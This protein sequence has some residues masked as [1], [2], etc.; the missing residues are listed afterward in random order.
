MATQWREHRDVLRCPT[1]LGSLRDGADSLECEACATTYPAEDGQV[2]LRIREPVTKE[3][4]F[5]FDGDYPDVEEFDPGLDERPSPAVDW[6]DQPLPGNLDE[7]LLS[8]F[9]KADSPGAKAIDV[10]CGDGVHEEVCRRAGYDWVGVDL[11]SETAPIAG[12][13]HALPFAD[14]TFDFA[15]SVAVLSNVSNPFVMLEEVH[16]VLAPDSTFIGT[17]AF[18]EAA[19]RNSLY[20]H[21]LLGTVNSLREAGF[22]VDRVGPGWHCT[23]ALG[24]RLFPK[25]PRPLLSLGERSV[26]LAHRFW[27]AVGRLLYDEYGA[28]REFQ[29]SSLTGAFRFVASKE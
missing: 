14:S 28:S 18:L 11:H 17:V 5:E 20:H 25:L 29:A 2:D 4:R 10:G 13:V 12:D 16:R 6:S 21:A 19:S 7:A 1:C 3:L 9:P 27:Y 24:K 15:L 8:H 22:T 23:A 26:Y